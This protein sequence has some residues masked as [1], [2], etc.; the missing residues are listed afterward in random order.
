MAVR[1][2]PIDEAKRYLENARTILSEKAKKD[3]NYYSDP[4]YVKIAGN[5]AWNGVLVALDSV[6][7]VRQNLKKGQRLEFKD[8]LDA[9]SKKDKKMTRPLLGAYDTL[10][11]SLGYDG[12]LI[13]KVVQT[14][15][16]HGKE[17]IAWAAKQ[18]KA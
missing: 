4:K 2:N 17:M 12:V 1:K 6:L 13:Y 3:G 10:H 8:Y 16:E 15:L 5:T 7:P 14:A 9:I 11:K 18:Y